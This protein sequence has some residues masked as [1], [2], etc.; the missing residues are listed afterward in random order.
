MRAGRS[1]EPT[2]P[3]AKGEKEADYKALADYQKAL[4][5]YKA[6]KARDEAWGEVEEDIGWRVG[7][8]GVFGLWPLT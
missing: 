4:T 2:A 6:N 7:W 8:A 1:P 3:V 5:A